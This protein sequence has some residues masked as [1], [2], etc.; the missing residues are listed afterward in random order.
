MGH[1]HRP[2]SD[3]EAVRRCRRHTEVGRPS[4]LALQLDLLRKRPRR[5]RGRQ[6]RRAPRRSVARRRARMGRGPVVRRLRD[7]RLEDPALLHLSRPGL[8]R[9]RHRALSLAAA[10]VAGSAMHE[11]VM[12]TCAVTGDLTTRERHPGLPG[13]PREIAEIAPTNVALVEKAAPIL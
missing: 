4:L 9:P 7:P 10:E 2:R 6:P 1:R 12:L 5:L 13:P 3:R 11:K 8:R